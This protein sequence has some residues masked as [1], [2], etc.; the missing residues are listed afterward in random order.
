MKNTV[1]L[2][3]ITI[4]LVLALTACGKID[5]T[6]LD[7]NDYIKRQAL[8]QLELPSDTQSD[9]FLMEEDSGWHDIWLFDYDATFILVVYAGDDIKGYE[10]NANYHYN[11]LRKDEAQWTIKISKEVVIHVGTMKDLKQGGE[12]DV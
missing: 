2:I 6:A 8:A 5:S 12:S 7:D 11:E 10:V 4:A 1:I 9:L 3:A